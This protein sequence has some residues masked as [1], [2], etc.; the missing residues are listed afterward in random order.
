MQANAQM[1]EQMQAGA[2]VFGQQLQHQAIGKADQLHRIQ[3]LGAHRVHRVLHKH[4]RLREGLP[5][6]NDF[7]HFL[8]T[9]GGDAKQL[10][11]ATEHQE[12]P[13]GRLALLQQQTVR[14]PGPLLRLGQQAIL[15]IGGK[16]VE[17]RVLQN[18]LTHV[19]GLDH[20]LFL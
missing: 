17:Q 1:P 8:L 5:G 9:I 11:P 19:E 3:G 14:R 2:R 20:L 13:F 10:D 7:D 4:H 15:R 12:K 18:Q 6:V 16:Q